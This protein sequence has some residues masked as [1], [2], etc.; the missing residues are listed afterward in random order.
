MKILFLLGATSRI[1]NFRDTLVLLADR[2][3]D[4]RLA[5]RLRKGSFELPDSVAHE[6]ISGRVNPT[7]RSDEW[8][9]FVDLLRGARDYARYFDPRYAQA[10]RLVRRA[11]EI[12]PT[13][14]ALFCERHPWVKTY[15]RLLGRAL[16]ACE[17]LIPA[18]PAFE[19]FLREERPDLMLV[20][21]LVTFESYQTDYVKAAHRLGIPVVFIPFSWDNLT[22]KGL[23]RIL[24]D[25]VLVW[26]EVQRREA[27]DL[28]GCPPETVVVTGAARFDDFFART[29]AT[30]REEFFAGFGLDPARPMVLYL[31]SSQLTGP[32][33]MELVRRWA[34]SIRAAADATLR[35]CGLLVR[36]HPAVRN[37]W[38]SVDLSDLGNVALSLDASRGG[39]QELFDSIHH[40]HAAVGLNTSAMLEAAIVGRPVHTLVMPGFDEGQIG[41]MHFHY[42]V[43]AYGG[44]ASVAHDFDGHHRQL[45]PVLRA[46]PASTAR[47]RGFAGQFLRP[48]GVDRPVAPLLAAEIERAAADIRKRPHVP[49][50]LHAPARRALYLWLR[51]RTAS[52]R[53]AAD[54][55]VIGTSLSLRPVR[56]ALEEVQQGTSLV[57]VG[58][59]TDSIGLELLYWIPFVR[60]VAG[61][62]GLPPERLVAL[63]H[64][65]LRDWYGSSVGRFLDT[66]TL[67]S[68]AELAEWARRTVP[69]H[70]QD[71]K[72]A[73]MAP[74][75]AEIVERAVR[76]FDVSEHQVLHPFLLFRTFRRLQADGELARFGEVLRHEPRASRVASPAGTTLVALSTEHTAALP[77]TPENRQFLA[78]LT[79]QA[80]QAGEVV[81]LDGLPLAA[82]V[83]TLA[84]AGAFVGPYGDLAVLAAWC[85]TPVTAYHSERLPPDHAERLEAAAASAGWGAVRVERSRRF[86]GLRLPVKVHA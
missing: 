23:M 30:T 72:Q 2:G 7:Q 64:G 78:E 18:D 62:Y 50:A 51:R 66:T 47:S 44:L 63:S 76:T 37:S 19:D 26:N 13:E 14:F 8:R 11:Y 71:P 58:P 45:A 12:A 49:A 24:P 85:R 46:E 67:F 52:R 43:E 20:T 28:H 53:G 22:N 41:T 40:A 68:G 80:A 31:G 55:T 73:V 69:Q 21:P 61:A 29:P 25:R 34:E 1:R 60:W 33:E 48:H 16:A 57:F 32:N 75:D 70:E 81:S 3:H 36:P 10:T 17:T 65:G 59:W 77:D 74:F 86:K 79:A 83:E 38:T 84:R 56:T 5:G 27:I 42:L 4:I 35:T 82:R 39:D 6:R 15:P 9:E 54:T